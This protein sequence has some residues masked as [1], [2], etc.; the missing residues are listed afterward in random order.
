[1]I[2]RKKPKPSLFD[3]L[4]FT[5]RVRD[6]AWHRSKRHLEWIR[7]LPCGCGAMGSQAAHV[8]L[9]SDGAMGRKPSDFF[10]VP[11]CPSCHRIQHNIGERSFWSARNQPSPAQYAAEAFG[12]RSPD[13]ATRDAARAWLW[14]G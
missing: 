9:G 4:I 13:A 5:G 10:T 14:R 12:Q 2:G 7:T 8:R 11:L 1:M 6:D 3:R